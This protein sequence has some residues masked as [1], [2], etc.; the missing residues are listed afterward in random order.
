MAYHQVYVIW[1]NPLFHDSLHK[2]LDH[3]DIKWIGA[4]SD[5]STAVDEISRL[6]PDTILI[7]EVKGTTTTTSFMKIVEQFE[8][9]LRVVGVSL[10]D[11]QLSIFQ[12][13]QQTVG[14]PDDLIRVILQ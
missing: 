9:D 1:A 10:D 2:L 11:N 14:Q 8:W 3:T 5:F 4:S 12:H 6:Q 13:A 7:E